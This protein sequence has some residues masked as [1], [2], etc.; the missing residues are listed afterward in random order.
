MINRM[1][2]HI[3]EGITNITRHS[4]MA[5]ASASAVTMTLLLVSL[6]IIIMVN[7][8]QLTTSVERQ[9]EIR[10]KINYE[11]ESSVVVLELQEKI[12]EVEGVISVTYSD[13]NKELNRLITSYPDLASIYETYRDN[14][15]LYDVFY[16]KVESGNL[17]HEITEQIKVFENVYDVD[18]GGEGVLELV[19]ILNNIRTGGILLVVGLTLLAIFLI[20]NTIKITILS[21]LD[22]IAIMRTVGATNGFIRAPF[23]V[24]GGI[25]GLLGAAIP[26][27]VSLVG[28]YY[29]SVVSGGYLFTEIFQLAPFMPFA[30]YLS[31]CLGLFGMVVGLLGSFISVTRYL[32]WKR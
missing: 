26:I 9:L 2:R 18:F 1:L 30:I 4:A 27:I 11:V 16:V 8:S 28:Y 7:V 31:A 12:K 14:N 29:I 21:R 13:K 22:E 32:R 5:I 24:E 20:A 6:V 17:L 25:I 10:V 19:A 3:K 23:L 15:P